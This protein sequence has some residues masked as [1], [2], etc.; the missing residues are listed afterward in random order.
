M[1]KQEFIQEA[2]LRLISARPECSM[3]WVADN[4]E[5]LAAF[6]YDEPYP[7]AGRV[8]VVPPVTDPKADE[9]EILAR[10]VYRLEEEMKKEMDRKYLERTGYEYNHKKT[11]I[12]SRIHKAFVAEGICTV[13]DM[14]KRGRT[15][16][17]KVPKV[18]RMCIELIDKALCNLY[19]IKTW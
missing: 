17:L 7:H 3:V 12:A 19:N 5:Q 6:L 9:I 16:I 8:R 4:A 18:G 13:G 1:T 15:G 14:L 11:N 10:E 2:A